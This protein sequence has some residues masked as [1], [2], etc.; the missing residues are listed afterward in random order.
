AN[1][2]LKERQYAVEAGTQALK[3]DQ[4]RVALTFFERALA[5][6]QRLPDQ[7]QTAL[8][9]QKIGHT[10]NRMGELEKA[11]ENARAAL[12]LSSQLGNKPLVVQALN[13]LAEAT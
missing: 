11:E 6:S 2:S 10:Y 7:G 1:E 4:N 3:A 12:A 8:I 5:L 9:F 13:T